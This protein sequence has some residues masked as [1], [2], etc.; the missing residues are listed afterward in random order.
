M[1]VGEFEGE[2]CARALALSAK[3]SYAKRQVLSYRSDTKIQIML[4]EFEEQN[5]RLAGK[6]LVK[7]LSDNL[8]QVQKKE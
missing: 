6:L 5:F 4:D 8:N 3:L 7:S 1:Q 2:R